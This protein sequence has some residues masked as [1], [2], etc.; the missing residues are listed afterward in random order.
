MVMVM[1]MMMMMMRRRRR[2][3]YMTMVP[4]MVVTCLLVLSCDAD[5]WCLWCFEPVCLCVF[6]CIVGCWR[7]C[8]SY[9]FSTLPS[10]VQADGCQTHGAPAIDWNDPFDC[11]W[12]GFWPL[13]CSYLRRIFTL[14]QSDS[15]HHFL[16]TS[17]SELGMLGPE[18]STLLSETSHLFTLWSFFFVLM[19]LKL[20]IGPPADAFLPLGSTKPG[21]RHCHPGC[22]FFPGSPLW[23]W[24]PG[25]ENGNPQSKENGKRR[26]EDTQLNAITDTP[27]DSTNTCRKI[28]CTYHHMGIY[29]I[30]FICIPSRKAVRLLYICL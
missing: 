19:S 6:V 7:M 9:V 11:G 13:T 5:I 1:V 30:L 15:P 14:H 12:K 29:S 3:F 25:A 16:W 17:P 24:K 27:S 23:W 4:I 21:T 26:R 10:Q 18:H 28:I 20:Y 8:F 2:M 22:C